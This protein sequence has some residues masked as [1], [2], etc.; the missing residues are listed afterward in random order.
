MDSGSTGNLPWPYTLR[1]PAKSTMCRHVGT[2]SDRMGRTSLLFSDFDL[3][4]LPGDGGTRPKRR[5]SSAGRMRDFRSNDYNHH[6]D[7]MDFHHI[8]PADDIL[9]LGWVPPPIHTP[10]FSFRSKSAH[11]RNSEFLRIFR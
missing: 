7:P 5:M 10:G 6:Y 4:K 3:R 8:R 2:S 1:F 9:L 11:T